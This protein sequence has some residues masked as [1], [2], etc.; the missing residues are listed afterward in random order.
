MFKIINILKKKNIKLIFL[1]KNFYNNKNKV[2]YYKFLKNLNF[3]KILNIN[4]LL[5]KKKIKNFNFLF[6]FFTFFLN[7]K[8]NKL[9]FLNNNILFN[10]KNEQI[11][12]N[13]FRSIIKIFLKKNFLFIKNNFFIKVFKYLKI[14]NYFLYNIK[15]AINSR[16]L[17][18][19]RINIYKSE[20]KKIFDFKKKLFINGLFKLNN[21][22]F[23][24]NFIN[25]IFL[26]KI[27]IKKILIK[28]I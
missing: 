22:Y 1:L 28:N 27:K 2:F 12:Y 7:S 23:L 26:K 14:K 25:K 13:I 11:K 6:L 15:K 24:K 8:N 5:N 21:L 10:I 16:K 20:Y 19:Y 18:N 9:K 4:L 3:L 17:K